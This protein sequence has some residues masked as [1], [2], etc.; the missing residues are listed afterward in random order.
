MS[1]VT[2]MHTSRFMSW[3][4]WRWVGLVATLICLVLSFLVGLTPSRAYETNHRSPRLQVVAST[5]IL[6][7]FAQQVGGNA[8]EV[9]SLVPSGVDPHSFEPSLAQIRSIAYAQVALTNHLLLEDSALTRAISANLPATALQVEV[10]EAA[11]RYGV[12]YLPLVEDPGLSTIWLGARILTGENNPASNVRPQLSQQSGTIAAVG[13]QYWPVPE[14][15]KN[16]AVNRTKTANRGQDY[17]KNGQV[18][19]FLTGTFGQVETY[20]NTRDGVCV[21]NA[22]VDDR[23]ELPAG[24]HTHLSWGFSAPGWY[25]LDLRGSYTRGGQLQQT[26]IFPLYFAVGVNSHW[27]PTSLKHLA[28]ATRLDEGHVDVT[29]DISD[30]TLSD[31]EAASQLVLLADNADPSR[32][33]QRFELGRSVIEVPNLAATKI[34]SQASYRHLGKPGA[35]IFILPQAVLGK[36]VHGEIDPHLWLS[37]PASMAYVQV[38]RDAFVAAQPSQ[39]PYFSKRTEAYLERLRNLHDWLGQTMAAI[40]PENRH[41]VTTHDAYGYLAKTYGLKVSGFV[42]PNPSI[43]PSA[44]DLVRLHRTVADERIPALFL[45][46][47]GGAG[48]AQ[49]REVAAAQGVRLCQL[50][51]DTFTPRGFTIRSGGQQVQSYEELMLT[52]GYNLKVC[53]DPEGAPPQLPELGKPQERKHLNPGKGSPESI[54]EK[55]DY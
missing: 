4:I 16:P 52:N 13:F 9:T 3:S 35:G 27:P 39:A 20:F 5:P 40:P 28:G 25:R 45:E 48:A 29:L 54:V 53:L 31:R 38:I 26:P 30:A 55:E 8:V 51:S 7:D 22:C 41:L 10:A 21:R 32:E 37:V 49:L 18:V 1:R 17:E 50:W 43:E 14:T 19:A 34:P 11:S 46:P 33:P 6:A 42:S 23:L 24:A 36:H 2:Q 47:F 44:R 12:Q 15:A